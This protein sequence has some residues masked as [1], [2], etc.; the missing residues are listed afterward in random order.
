MTSRPFFVPDWHRGE[1]GAV[2]ERGGVC[3]AEEAGRLW[4]SGMGP[5]EIA[6]R[7]GVD[8]AWVETVISPLG[9]DGEPEAEN[10]SD[11]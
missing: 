9:K 4:R 7:M 5:E 2:E 3:L 8:A 1:E 10:G 11:R 6:G